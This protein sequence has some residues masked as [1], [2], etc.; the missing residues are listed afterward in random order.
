MREGV[1]AF[2]S[3]FGRSSRPSDGKQEVASVG[4]WEPPRTCSTKKTNE[5]L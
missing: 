2:S 1:V 3:S 4:T 5:F